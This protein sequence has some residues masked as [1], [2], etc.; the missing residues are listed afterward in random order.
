M[1]YARSLNI[2]VVDYQP[3]DTYADAC[4]ALY[5]KYGKKPNNSLNIQ[6]LNLKQ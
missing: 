2:P 4:N 6:H 1:D 5:D 3:E